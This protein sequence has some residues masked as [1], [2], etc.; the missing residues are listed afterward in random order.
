M[1]CK[2]DTVAV[3]C[4]GVTLTGLEEAVARVAVDF[5]PRPETDVWW[6]ELRPAANGAL[7][8]KRCGAVRERCWAVRHARDC[9]LSAAGALDLPERSLANYRKPRLSSVVRRLLCSRKAAGRPSLVVVPASGVRGMRNA[10]G[11]DVN[12]VARAVLRSTTLRPEV[13]SVRCSHGPRQQM[14]SCFFTRD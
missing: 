13:K 9:T 8:C 4:G 12:G 10:T 2:P 1:A 11:S 3:C 6:D 7:Q 5:S 14:K